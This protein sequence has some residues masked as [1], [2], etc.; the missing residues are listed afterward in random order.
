MLP[1]L[2]FLMK[3]SP[4]LPVKAA[5]L[6]A[7][8]VVSS[9][10]AFGADD[11]PV[12]YSTGF[13]QPDYTPKDQLKDERFFDRWWG[14]GDGGSCIVKITTEEAHEGVQSLMM[15]DRTNTGIPFVGRNMPETI[16]NAEIS[17]AVKMAAP[18]TAW[19][20]DFR[21]AD[22]INF[23]VFH[24][25]N[26]EWNECG[27]IV[28]TE[29]TMGHVT[30]EDFIKGIPDSEIGYNPTEWNLLTYRFDDKTKTFSLSVNG[31]VVLTIEKDDRVDW[32]F[33]LLRLT[34][35]WGAGN[36]PQLKAWFDDLTIAGKP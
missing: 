15:E 8:L 13:E 36:A 27:F 18:D 9:F 35:G 6:A 14:S 7:S 24:T 31:K 2:P 32:K 23:M 11:L 1:A 29:K 33:N 22:A 26:P 10:P 34:V 17:V 16:T 30:P 3:C 28:R 12:I 20:M 25:W 19:G 5:I 21:N 4:K